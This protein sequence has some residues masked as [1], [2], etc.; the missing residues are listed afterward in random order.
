M[1]DG[2]GDMVTS[3]FDV[4]VLAR[5]VIPTEVDSNYMGIRLEINGCGNLLHPIQVL[6][7]IIAVSLSHLTVTSV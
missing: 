5:T 7:L 6:F 3:Y 4:P 1:A 2:F